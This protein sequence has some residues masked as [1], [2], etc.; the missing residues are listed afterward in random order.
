MTTTEEEKMDF[1]WELWP[2]KLVK[3]RQVG[4]NK[5]KR[6]RPPDDLLCPICLD[7]AFDPVVTDKC[8]H[9][10]CRQC[11]G[12]WMEG[13]K[14]CPIDRIPL[15]AADVRDDLRAWR[16]VGNLQCKCKKTGCQWKGCIDDLPQHCKACGYKPENNRK[17]KRKEKRE[18]L[19]ESQANFGDILCSLVIISIPVI[20][21][22]NAHWIFS[23]VVYVLGLISSLFIFVVLSTFSIFIGCGQI[24]VGLFFVALFVPTFCIM[25]GIVVLSEKR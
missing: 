14:Q 17:R 9:L 24:L 13:N 10:F 3:K 18:N 19:Q 2:P 12:T 8:G 16:Q 11:L 22:Y 20:L 5:G 21:L 23:C 25:S 1:L 7:L 6:V 4:D 15:S